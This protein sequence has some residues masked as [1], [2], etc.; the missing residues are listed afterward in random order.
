MKIRFTP[1]AAQELIEARVWYDERQDG[2]GEEFQHSF[3][4]AKS[5]R[6]RSVLRPMRLSTRLDAAY[7]YVAFPTSFFT[8]S[9]VILSMLPV[10]FTSLE[11][12]S[13][14]AIDA[15]HSESPAGHS[16]DGR[17]CMLEGVTPVPTLIRS[18]TSSSCSKSGSSSYSSLATC[19]CRSGMA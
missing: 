8:K 2:L 4:A 6:F 10:A 17:P 16:H 18:P 9:R 13:S 14:G 19:G 1:E 5:L 3:D 15:T 11:I 12:Q 7:S